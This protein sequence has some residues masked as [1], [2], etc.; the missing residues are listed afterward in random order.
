M[1]DEF[2]D[3]H[4]AGK[5]IKVRSWYNNLGLSLKPRRY[6]S[7]NWISFDEAFYPLKWEHLPRHYIIGE[8]T[9]TNWVFHPTCGWVEISS[10]EN[11]RLDARYR[12]I[13]ILVKRLVDGYAS[14]EVLKIMED[15]AKIYLASLQ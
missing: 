1:D 3:I 7:I 2:E 9:C 14:E 10:G 5:K 13:E 11:I 8:N 4:A 12:S 6:H 15:Y